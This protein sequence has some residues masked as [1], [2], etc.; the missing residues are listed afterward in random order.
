MVNFNLG[1]RE[2]LH[3]FVELSISYRKQL[4]LKKILLFSEGKRLRLV[5]YVFVIIKYIVTNRG[6]FYS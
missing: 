1:S 5:Y 6:S 3:V 4:K 2:Y